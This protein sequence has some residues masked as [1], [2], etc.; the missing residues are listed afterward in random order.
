MCWLVCCSR[1]SSST[2]LVTHVAHA[3]AASIATHAHA[4]VLDPSSLLH[5]AHTHSSSDRFHVFFVDFVNVRS[6]RSSLLPLHASPS[7]SPSHPPPPLFFMCCCSSPRAEQPQLTPA[8]R[9]RVCVCSFSPRDTCAP[10]FFCVEEHEHEHDDDASTPPRM[11]AARSPSSS[12]SSLATCNHL[13]HVLACDCLR[14][15]L[16]SSVST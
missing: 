6:P 5:A 8:T 7:A 10:F 1:S 11:H 9:D 14:S 4:R 3:L 15:S 12:S 16:S 2:P 13:H